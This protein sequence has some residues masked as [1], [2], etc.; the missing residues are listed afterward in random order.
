MMIRTVLRD[1]LTRRLRLAMTALAI[2]LGVAFMSGSFVFSST[3]THSL[4]S[5]FATASNGTD[6]I[7]QHISPSG[8]SVGGS[9]ARP[10]PASVLS[11]VRSVRGV[12]VADGTDSG[13]ATMLGK[14]G[15]AMKTAFGVALSWPA[16]PAFQTASTG[17][18]GL[19]PVTG[20]Q[21]MIDRASAASGGYHVGDTIGIAIGGRAR[22]FT[23]SGIT[24][25][26]S[27]SSI[28]GGSM[29]IFTVPEVQSLFGKAG[30]YDQ[31]SVKATPGVSASVLRDR[32]GAVLPSGVQA[33]TAASAAANEA[34]QLNSQLSVLI[35][36]FLGFAGIALF[37]GAFVI[38]N[39][40]SIMVGQRTRALALLRALGAG[41]GQVFRSVLLEAL[42][43]S[44]IASVAGVFAG[45]GLARG[46]SALLTS[47]GVSLPMTSLSVPLSGVLIALGAGIGVTLAASLSPAMKATRVP[48]VAA[49]RSV[50]VLPATT[51]GW[52]R[53]VAGSVL[54]LAGLGF[55]LL[56]GNILLTGIG[57]LACFIGVTVLAPVVV[58]PLANAIGWFLRW[59]PGQAGT[60][61]Q[62]NTARSPRRVAA[63]AASLMIGLAV[64]S[65]IAVL[66]SSAQSSVG[67]QIN[68][69]SRTSYYVQAVSAGNGI[70]P[71]LA[72]SL[73]QV[74]GVSGVTE[75]RLADATVNGQTHRNV[76]GIDPAAVSSFTSLGVVY[77][78]VAALSSGGL[79][80]TTSEASA[81]GWQLGSLVPVQ[82][83]SYGSYRLPVV[84]LFTSAGPLSGYLVSL[85]TFT[86][87]SGVRVDSVDL[88]RAPASA[89]AG[90]QSALN[91]Y[92]GAQLL[93]QAGYV[94][95]QTAVLNSLMNLVTALL[96]LAIIIAL[97][98]VVN[99]LALSI[100]ERTREIGLLRAI[101]MRRGQVRL[102]VAAESAIISVIGAL[103]GIVLGLGLGVALA[104]ALTHGAAVTIPVSNLIIYVL[105][106]GAAGVLASL[107]P[108]RRAARLNV[109]SAIA[110]E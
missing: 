18:A 76:S 90:L 40:F 105:A 33:V 11:V 67:S 64:I 39:T 53:L 37:T 100:V 79:M 75:V 41:R 92:P 86:A 4:D 2:A 63:T 104:S 99:T 17:R 1:M 77:G 62:G 45:L 88:V 8:G 10:V 31:I 43:V 78:S 32:I 82:F 50:A 66:V 15:K 5:L 23:I 93:D 108:A 12:A 44:V 70:D 94:K 58:A 109:L 3:L 72:S 13:T 96:I 101:G 35:H 106:T 102:M 68:T 80:V 22:V 65:G 81:A 16:D 73:R 19:P 25:Y 54:A 28:G 56:N 26:G 38:W 14:N 30:L 6:V 59:L 9:S 21:V 36:F 20:S 49:M 85:P 84:G 61:A 42:L 103:L 51:L 98:G 95:N 110:A 57:A 34:S 74:P 7:V 89:R 24:G 52:R 27:G 60:L 48:P 87:D 55:I 69:A 91:G 107:A 71:A 47:F 29:A 83:G 97:L 46:L